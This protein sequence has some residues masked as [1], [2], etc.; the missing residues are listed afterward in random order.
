MSD[1]TL[2]LQESSQEIKSFGSSLDGYMK[3]NG[4]QEIKHNRHNHDEDIISL[5]LP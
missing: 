4:A 1:N 5:A 2:Q 3:L